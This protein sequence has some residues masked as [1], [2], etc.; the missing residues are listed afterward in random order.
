MQSNQT[1]VLTRR[2]YTMKTWMK[3][4]YAILGLPLMVGSYFV[5]TTAAFG[6]SRSASII[7]A[8]FFLGGGIYVFASALRSRLVIDGSRIEVQTAFRERTADLGEIEG[9]RTIQT[10]NSSYTQLRL[11]NGA[12]TIAIPNIF[13]VDEDYRRWLA[14]IP[15]LDERDRDALLSEIKQSAELGGTPDERM[16][17]L[18]TA[19]TIGIFAT[20]VAVVLAVASNI[21]PG[22]LGLLSGALLA[23]TPVWVLV[24]IKQSPL[25][26]AIFKRKADP[27][28]DLAFVLMATSFGYLFAISGVHVVSIKPLVPLMLALLVF[29]CAPVLFVAGG[30]S[31]LMGRSIALVFFAGLYGYSLTVALNA[32]LDKGQISPYRSTVTRKYE[33]HGRSTSYTLYLAPWGP[34]EGTNRVGVSS[35]VYQDTAIGDSVCLNLH[36][37][38]LH[39]AW[40][41][42]V[43]CSMQ[44]EPPLQP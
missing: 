21:A 32:H 29:Y 36:P 27:R 22:F 13:D 41:E 1:A 14:Q 7:P 5:A 25:L 43:D 23:I 8:L 34:F 9:Y 38:A 39:A 44:S 11:K 12:G 33:S 19:K 10:R 4:L 6:P 20:V 28:A 17:A 3:L 42:V 2:E 35:R 16:A 30:V 31:Q 24:M 26:Y 18:A 15:N 40:F 37:G